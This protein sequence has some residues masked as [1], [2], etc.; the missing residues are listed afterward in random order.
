MFGVP[1][2]TL[3]GIPEPMD[4][5]HELGCAG[6]LTKSMTDLADQVGEIRFYDERVFPHTIQQHRFG[7]CPR[8]V[9]DQDLEQLKGLGRQGE[10]VTA[11]EQFAGVG[12][13]NEV[14]KGNSLEIVGHDEHGVTV[15]DISSLYTRDRDNDDLLRRAVDVPALPESWKEYLRKRLFEPDV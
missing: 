9:F 2:D 4:R 14:A 15:A 7:Q 13:K 3:K 1:L 10:S 11:A 12:V 8:P 5:S 6:I